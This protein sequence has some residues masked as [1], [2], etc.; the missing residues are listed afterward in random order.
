MSKKTRMTFL[1]RSEDRERMELLR[2]VEGLSFSEII[3][4]GIVAVC[5]IKGYM[6]SAD[7]ALKK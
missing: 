6:K 3:R 4:A 7:E 1:V 5:Q 2:A